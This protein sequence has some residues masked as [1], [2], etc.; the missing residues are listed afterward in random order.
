M[1]NYAAV[2]SSLNIRK[3]DWCNKQQSDSPIAEKKLTPGITWN[4]A[5]KLATAKVLQCEI[6]NSEAFE[7]TWNPTHSIKSTQRCS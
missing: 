1:F 2:F 5:R 3:C 6:V 7:A 4:V